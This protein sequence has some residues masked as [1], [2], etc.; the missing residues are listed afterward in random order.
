MFKEYQMVVLHHCYPLLSG[1]KLGDL[2][3][4]TSSLVVV[5]IAIHPPRNTQR[6]QVNTVPSRS[7]PLNAQ[8]GTLACRVCQ[9]LRSAQK[10]EILGLMENWAKSHSS[11][12]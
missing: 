2:K 6:C 11:G 10:T 5:I 4:I 1:E 3:V 12:A 8:G 9:P 7:L